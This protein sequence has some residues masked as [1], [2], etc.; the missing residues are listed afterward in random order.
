MYF[1]LYCQLMYCFFTKSEERYTRSTTSSCLP[2]FS[3]MY[4]CSMHSSS[5]SCSSRLFRDKTYCFLL[6]SSR[7]LAA[8]SSISRVYLSSI[9]ICSLKYWNFCC[10]I[11]KFSCTSLSSAPTSMILPPYIFSICAWI[12]S[13]IS[14]RYPSSDHRWFASSLHFLC[15]VWAC[16]TSLWGW[17]CSSSLESMYTN[18]LR[19]FSEFECLIEYYDGEW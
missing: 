11:L 1:A 17:S 14:R 9:S 6:F 3:M 13:F 18:F 4:F 15:T 12:S 16:S 5:L 19:W 7:N 8:F 2:F 10:L